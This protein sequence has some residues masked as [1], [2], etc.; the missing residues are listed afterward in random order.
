MEPWHAWTLIALAAW[1]GLIALSIRLTR[2]PIRDDDF[3]AELLVL[4]MHIYARLVHRIRIEGREHIPIPDARGRLPHPLI[5][6]ANHTAGVDPVLIQAAIRFEPRWMMAEDMRARSLDWLWSKARIIFVD[7][8]TRESRSAREALR[9]LKSGGVLGVFPEGHIERPPEHLLPFRGG[10]GF[11]IA[12]SGAPVLPVVIS[13]T[14][15]VDP[16]WA[17]LTRTSRSVVRFL[18]MVRYPKD[19]T[20]DAIAGDLFRRFAEATG[21]PPAPRVPILEN[22]R[23]ILVDIEGRYIDERGD[24]I[25]DEEAATASRSRTPEDSP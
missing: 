7:R 25:S 24:P 21:W 4:A 5:V 11:L 22:G 18:P 3:G 10:V 9:H 14:P 6:A 13:G 15:Q 19:A 2:S 20:P 12:K 23:R 8:S 1:A 17:S 16:A